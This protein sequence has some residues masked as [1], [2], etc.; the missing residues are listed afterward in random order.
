MKKTHSQINDKYILNNE[1]KFNNVNFSYEKK[2]LILD[3]LNFVIKKNTI[4]GIIGPSG[5]GKSTLLNL[6]MGFLNPDRGQIIIDN[7]EINK[8]KVNGKKV[9]VMFHKM[10]I[11]L[12]KQLSIILHL[13]KIKKI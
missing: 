6:F 3:N 12:M 4:T 9:S 2:N 7:L 10:F 1:I 8:I 11:C 5:S 13:V